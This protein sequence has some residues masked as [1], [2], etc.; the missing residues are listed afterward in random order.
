MSDNIDRL[1]Q[2]LFDSE[3]QTLADLARRIEALAAEAASAHSELAA[4]L[5]DLGET[6]GRTRSQIAAR[7]DAL[8]ARVG[9]DAQLEAS[10]AAILD[11]AL[12]KADASKH[13]DVADAV[14][15]FV[16]KTVRTEIRNS[17][18]E[19]VEA[20][21]PV[22]GRIVKSYVASAMKD[23]VAQINR[24]LET[25]P[26][27]LRIQSLATGRSVAELAIAASQ[28]LDVEELYLIRRGTGELVERWPDAAG[29]G[30]R[31]QVM[32]GVLAAINEFASQAFEAS[33]NALRQIDLGDDRVYLRES[34]TYLLAAKCS[35]S[36]S[37]PVEEVLDDGFLSA[38]SGLASSEGSDTRPAVLAQLAETLTARLGETQ[39]QGAVRRSG[40]NPIKLVA[41]VVGLP[42]VLWFAWNTYGHW[43][44]ARVDR[45]ARAVLSAS[46]EIKGYPSRV[47][48]DWLG[49][50]MTVAGLV[51]TL[52][53][54]EQVLRQLADALP[55]TRV[56]DEFAVVPNALADVEPELERLQDK[57]AAI[58]PELERLQAR[59]AVIEPSIG[60]VREE[61]AA[62]ERKFA[63]DAEQADIARASRR[64]ARAKA[65]I[66]SLLADLSGDRERAVR[67]TV[68]DLDRSISELARSGTQP[69]G[70]KELAVIAERT[71]AAS[72][73]LAT[74]LTARPPSEKMI[75]DIPAT[76]A[77]ATLAAAEEIDMVAVALAQ[78][79]ALQRSLPVASAREKLGDWTDAN[80]IF[81]SEET[82]YREPDVALRKVAELA[83]LLRSGDLVVRVV[84]YTDGLGGADR[85]APLSLA[86]A[87]KVAADL[88][89]KGVPASQ[90]ITIGRA[91]PLDI[92]TEAGAGSPN[93]RVEFEPGFEGEA[94]K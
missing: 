26:L 37:A 56:Q 3:T 35:G 1:K 38:M 45:I 66:E 94:R 9:D 32:S 18:D 6:E 46:A 52:T 41:W 36:A 21:Y 88:R 4:A 71:R 48:T 85:N 34:P 92:S 60:K 13:A 51:P 19:L 53:A 73:N 14:A 40:F 50:S 70:S 82:D 87:E 81:F 69:L 57:T 61:V 93:R 90:I 24:R 55:D 76:T 75:G 86:R 72:R 39:E 54:K 33:S 79:V 47:S 65:T 7:L 25:N 84:G 20:L 23:L 49:R 22:T 80:A 42:L 5:K 83:E 62:L 28:R 77:G 15:P 10:V 27:M 67:E 78:T 17:K 16:V 64:L 59:T 29:G 31:D 91:L 58:E 63:R 30:N 43:Q 11:G 44:T 89:A 74:M 68:R 8:A 12:R 2:L